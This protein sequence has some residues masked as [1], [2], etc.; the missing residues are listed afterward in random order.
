MIID[1]KL[2]GI[3]SN[4]C[5]DI[6]KAYFIAAFV[7]PPLSAGSVLVTMLMLI[8]GLIAAILFIVLS[9]QFLKLKDRSKDESS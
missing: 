6:A 1:P 9:W 2:A 4:F 7:T 3:L 5:L 8:R